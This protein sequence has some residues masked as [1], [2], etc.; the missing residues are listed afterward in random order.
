[1]EIKRKEEKGTKKNQGSCEGEYARKK[2]SF[3]HWYSTLLL[4]PTTIII[5]CNSD[6][7]IKRE[8]TILKNFHFV[9]RISHILVY[10][11]DK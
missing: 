1:M 11:Y 5:Q 4:Q 3:E 6:S 10:Y 2:K 9:S 8:S 7:L